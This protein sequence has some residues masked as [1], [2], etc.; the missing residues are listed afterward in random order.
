PW[1]R[2]GVVPRPGG[3]RAALRSPAIIGPMDLPIGW[4]HPHLHQ[5]RIG[6]VPHVFHPRLRHG[7]GLVA[8]FLSWSYLK[9]LH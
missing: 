1:R 9:I 6:Q 7:Q 2:I 4:H 5:G 8:F 3:T